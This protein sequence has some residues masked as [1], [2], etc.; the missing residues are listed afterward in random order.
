VT[1][2]CPTE[3]SYASPS[4][5]ACEN[6]T[7]TVQYHRLQKAIESTGCSYTLFTAFPAPRATQFSMYSFHASSVAS[8]AA[9][10]RLLRQT[11]SLE[12]PT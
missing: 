4:L 8:T 6:T 3:R 2:E 7:D 11:G 10:S 5:P 9:S 12:A 1:T